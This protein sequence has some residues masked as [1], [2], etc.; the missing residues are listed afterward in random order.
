MTR[1]TAAKSFTPI[2]SAHIISS[3]LNG[4]KENLRKWKTWDKI[5]VIQNH[6]QIKDYLFD[7]FRNLHV[8]R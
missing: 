6:Q 8:C 3:P 2:A 7:L 5:T 4:F 1:G